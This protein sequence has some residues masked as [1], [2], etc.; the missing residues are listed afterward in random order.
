MSLGGDDD[1][2]GPRAS[3][4][5]PAHN[6]PLSQRTTAP[7]LCGVGGSPATHQLSALDKVSALADQYEPG[8]RQQQAKSYTLSAPNSLTLQFPPQREIGRTEVGILRSHSGRFLTRRRPVHF[9]PAHRKKTKKKNIQTTPNKRKLVFAF[10][11]LQW[12]L[13]CCTSCY[14]RHVF[15]STG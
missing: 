14:P 12:P 10:T 9:R 13:V 5:S 4:V 6:G 8:Q 7:F 1:S 2:S 15:R 11:K 3:L